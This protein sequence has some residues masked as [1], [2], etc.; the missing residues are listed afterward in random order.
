M[1]WNLLFFGPLY[2]VLFLSASPG[3][4][5]SAA[6]GYVK[7]KRIANQIFNSHKNSTSYQFQKVYFDSPHDKP[8]VAVIIGNFLNL[9]TK[10]SLVL[11]STGDERISVNLFEYQNSTWKLLQS[12]SVKCSSTGPAEKFVYI[13][14]LGDNRSKA[15][16]LLT[17]VWLIR[18]GENYRAFVLRIKKLAEIKG[19]EDYV[20][21]VYDP[22]TKRIYS[23]MG[24]GCA[25]MT[26]GFTEG[27][28]VNNALVTLN[29]IGCDC[30]SEGDSC[31]ISMNNSQP[32][33]VLYDS[34]YK[35]V[36]PFYQDF[37]RDK[38]R[39]VKEN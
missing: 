11:Y 36:P 1:K 5:H 19:F 38:L 39:E 25:D 22:Q 23:Y 7:Y 24:T 14:D 28:I 31:I 37:L 12:K 34:S 18:S 8:K 32:F 35:Y 4:I 13:V 29:E 9:K 16:L 30:C 33:N 27:K 2:L 15:L 20:N 10:N 26:M 6:G 3:K 17:N 21:P